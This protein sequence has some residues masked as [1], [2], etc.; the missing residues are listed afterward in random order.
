MKIFPEIYN[1]YTTIDL[2][3]TSRIGI[4]ITLLSFVDLDNAD[5]ALTDIETKE[6]ALQSSVT[7]ME[8]SLTAV[9]TS[10]D[11]IC[12]SLTCPEYATAL[13]TDLDSD[14]V[15]RKQICL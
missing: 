10:L 8:A 3:E 2:N 13:T 9:K 11:T 7:T 6:S 4:I 14:N 5:T 12:A 15:S 1:H